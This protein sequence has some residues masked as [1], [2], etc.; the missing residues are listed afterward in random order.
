M[1]FNTKNQEWDYYRRILNAP[2]LI[3]PEYGV[4]G[5]I[6]QITAEQYIREVARITRSTYESHMHILTTQKADRKNI[7][8][9][10]QLECPIAIPVLNYTCGAQEGRHRA[11][12]FSEVHGEDA[13][14]P[15]LLVYWIDEQKKGLTFW[16]WLHK[17]REEK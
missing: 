15:C 6:I 14:F 5:K 1:I 4:R 12:A 17:H 3:V 9:L 16:Q 2:D 8:N 13:T 11:V 10:K 7:E